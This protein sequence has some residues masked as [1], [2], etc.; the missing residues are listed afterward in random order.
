MRRI[1]PKA[2]DDADFAFYGTVLGGQHAAAC[3]AGRAA[4]ICSTTRWARRSASSTSRSISRRRPR[5]RREQ[6]VANLLKAYDAASSTLAWMSAATQAEGARQAAQVHAAR[7]AIPTSGATI[8]RSTIT[9]DDLIGNVQ[10]A[11]RCSS[12][13]RELERLDQP[14][15]STEWGMTPP[16]VNAYYNPQLQRDR[17]PGRASCSRRSSIRTPTTRS[18]TAASAR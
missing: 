14:V 4:C 12:G 1:L 9:R 13:N 8:P 5:R 3:R 15:D 17:V 6:L 2:F 7:S 18:T 11:Q 16:T 10:R